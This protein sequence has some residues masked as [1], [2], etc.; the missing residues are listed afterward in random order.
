MEQFFQEGRL[1]VC[2]VWGAGACATLRHGEKNQ[3]KAGCERDKTRGM[4]HNVMEDSRRRNR[5]RPLLYL[6]AEL[7]NLKVI[8]QVPV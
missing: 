4:K 8:C 6:Q 3:T 5:D 7:G 2:L 1:E